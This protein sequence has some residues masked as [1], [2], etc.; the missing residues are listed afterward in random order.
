MDSCGNEARQAKKLRAACD[1]LGGDDFVWC[2]GYTA[3]AREWAQAGNCTK[4]KKPLVAARALLRAIS[5]R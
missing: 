1:R 5:R 3:G 2:V 4:A